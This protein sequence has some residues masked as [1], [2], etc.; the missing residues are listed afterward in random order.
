MKAITLI[1]ALKNK[2]ELARAVGVSKQA[3]NKWL[4]NNNIPTWHLAK[5]AE[6]LGITVDQAI[7]PDLEKGEQVKFE[8]QFEDKILQG[9][10]FLTVRN[11]VRNETFFVQNEEFKSQCVH[12]M[13]SDSFLSLVNKEMFNCV[14]FGFKSSLDMYAYYNEYFNDEYDTAYIHTISDSML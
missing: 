1:K 9:S 14:A 4:K 7:Q 3:V 12:S 11:K 5:V 6:Y 8:K 13:N 2:S 10:K